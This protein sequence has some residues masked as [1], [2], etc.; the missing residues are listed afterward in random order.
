MGLACLFLTDLV[1]QLVEQV[2]ARFGR[3]V[4]RTEGW[5][6]RAS[7]AGLILIGSGLLM[8]VTALLRM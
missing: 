5:N 1:W 6:A 3:H 2:N 4:A 7:F 8:L